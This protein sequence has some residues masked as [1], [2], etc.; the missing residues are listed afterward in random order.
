MVG[1]AVEYTRRLK[2]PVLTG[3]IFTLIGTLGLS[4]LT[5]NLPDQLY[6]LILLPTSIGQGFQFPGTFMAILVA[7]TQAEQ[8]VVT[9]TLILWR[10]I[11]QVLGVASSSL[12][13]QNALNYYLAQ[14]VQGDQS[15]DVISRVR[16]SVEEVLKLEPP[17]QDQVRQSYEAALHLTFMTCAVFAAASVLMV[18]PIKLPRLGPKK[19]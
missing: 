5:S 2:W 11:G 19:R 3:T 6:L 4:G 8:A 14:Y 16:K 17:Y 18:L 7:S 13:L 10:C 12:V 15:A 9:S 1:F